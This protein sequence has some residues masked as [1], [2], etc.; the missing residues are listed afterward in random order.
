MLATLPRF[1][2]PM[3]TPYQTRIEPRVEPRITPFLLSSYLKTFRIRCDFNLPQKGII[4][5]WHQDLAVAMRAFSGFGIR[6]LLSASRDGDIAASV[7]RSFGYEVL[8]GSSSRQGAAALRQLWRLHQVFPTLIGM[9]L[10]GPRGPAF[11][12]KPG[13]QW[14]SESLQIPI[15]PLGIAIRRHATLKSSWDQARLPWPFIGRAHAYLGEPIHGFQGDLAAAMQTARQ[16]AESGLND[17]PSRNDAGSPKNH[18]RTDK[19]KLRAFSGMHSQ[20]K[21]AS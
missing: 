9:A 7:A 5:L 6:V 10:D 11:T 16:A 2:A 3:T 19:K 15:Y 17:A 21:G 18:L 13:T 1:N 12:L 4:A 14:L 8:R 20:A